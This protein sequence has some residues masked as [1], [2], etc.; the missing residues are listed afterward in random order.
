MSSATLSRTLNLRCSDGAA[1]TTHNAQDIPHSPSRLAEDFA[2]DDYNIT[3]R[4]SASTQFNMTIADYQDGKWPRNVRERVELNSTPIPDQL[5]RK[6]IEDMLPKSIFEVED[7]DDA[8]PGRSFHLG[9]ILNPVWIDGPKVG[10]Q[11]TGHAEANDVWG[12]ETDLRPFLGATRWGR[13]DDYLIVQDATFDGDHNLIPQLAYIWRMIPPI[14]EE[15][16][17]W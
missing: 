1:Q 15:V 13:E 11:A 9:T 7:I 17:I 14:I 8:T 16:T 12:P 3:A 5:W 2:N 6:D 10:L 4:E